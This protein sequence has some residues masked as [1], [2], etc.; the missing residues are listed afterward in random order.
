MS[1]SLLEFANKNESGLIL[2]SGKSN[3]DPTKP[4]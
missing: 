2:L 1:Y 4:D 3:P